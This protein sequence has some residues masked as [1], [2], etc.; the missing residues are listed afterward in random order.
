MNKKNLITYLKEID[1]FISS[2]TNE[3]KLTNKKFNKIYSSILKAQKI[4]I[5]FIFCHLI[6]FKFLTFFTFKK[7]NN[8]KIL[9]IL[10]KINFL[11]FNKILQLFFAF[12]K[13]AEGNNERLLKKKIRTEKILDQDFHENIVVGSGPSGCITAYK[14]CKAGYNTLIIEK[15]NN[16]SLPKYKHPFSEFQKKWKYSGI[17]GAL[18][19][20]DFQYASGEC[21]GGGSEI[22]SG[23]YHEID[24]NFLNNLKT[25]NKNNLLKK[26]KFEWEFLLG[27]KDDKLTTPEEKNLKNYFFYGAKKRSLKIEDLKIF[28][29]NNKKNSMSE[30]ILQEAKKKGC[31]ILDNAE[32]IKFKKKKYWEIDLV[33]DKKKRT[34][35]SKRL[36]LCCGAPYSLNLLKKSNCVDKKFNQ[37]FHFH[38]MI[39]IVAKFPKKVNS[40]NNVNVINTQVSEFYPNYL[41][42]NAA[43]NYEFLKIFSFGNNEMNSDIDKNFE[44]MSIFHVTFSLGNVNFFKIPFVDDNIIKYK[45][46]DNDLKIIDSGFRNLIDFVF[47]CGAEYI[48]IQDEK[49]SKI[50]KSTNYE[51]ILNSYKYNFSSVHLLGGLKFGD[52]DDAILN[53]YGKFKNK[54]FNNLYVNDSSLLTEKLL[55]N[56]QGSIMSITSQNIDQ[57]ILNLDV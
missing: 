57:I 44:Y 53:S 42:G 55:K 7:K 9:K 52:S 33:V 31:S 30:T 26:K 54:K 2:F 46:S 41:F 10:K 47:N 25:N 1:F 11:K 20:Y 27:N 3:K 8:L 15:G 21:V 49:I 12:K 14:L 5:I 56:P 16:Y 29:R 23:L 38:P 18:G 32:V 35:F 48:Y 39:K 6:L 45:F 50:E 43:S 37:N 19:K 51:N 22:N 40:I 34:I 28:F 4:I 24:E 36:F 13:L 17:S